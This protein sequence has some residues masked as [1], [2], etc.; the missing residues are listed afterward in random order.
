ML[1]VIA[2]NADDNPHGMSLLFT[3]RAQ[4]RTIQALVDQGLAQQPLD[5]R[6]VQLTPAGYSAIG[7]TGPRA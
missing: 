1:K 5:G 2:G 3:T 6:W 4:G 7:R